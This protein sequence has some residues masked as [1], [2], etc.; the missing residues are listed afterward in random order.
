MTVIVCF[1]STKADIL[2]KEEKMSITLYDYIQVSD[3][4]IFGFAVFKLITATWLLTQSKLSS[5]FF[6]IIFSSVLHNSDLREEKHK[7]SK[8]ED[9]T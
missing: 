3:T 4:N 7:H 6:N 5:W 2:K 1:C 8:S 9:S